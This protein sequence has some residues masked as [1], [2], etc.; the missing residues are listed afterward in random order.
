MRSFKSLHIKLSWL[1]N[2]LTSEL[3]MRSTRRALSLELEARSWA[4]AVQC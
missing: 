4:G 2:V 1:W 3:E